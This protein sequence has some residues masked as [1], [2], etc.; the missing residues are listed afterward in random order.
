TAD[1]WFRRTLLRLSNKSK[2]SKVR[3][4]QWS[5]DGEVRPVT[6]GKSK[7]FTGSEDIPPAPMMKGLAPYRMKSN[8]SYSSQA[9]LM[10]VDRSYFKVQ[11]GAPGRTRYFT[12]PSKA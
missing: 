8:L 4:I 3:E 9:P 12:L 5:D 7:Q 6:R 10:T 11:K 1:M 2:K